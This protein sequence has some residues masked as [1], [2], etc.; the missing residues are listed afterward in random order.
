M[1]LSV[2]FVHVISSFVMF[3][4]WSVEVLTVIRDGSL[5]HEAR[6]GRVLKILSMLLVLATGSY[7]MQRS[8]GPQPWLVVSVLMLLSTIPLSI[9]LSICPKRSVSSENR[10]MLFFVNGMYKLATALGIVSLMVFKDQS[11]MSI[12]IKVLVIYGIILVPSISFYKK[13]LR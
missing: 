4:M 2:L 5:E 12:L 3:S 11:Y 7:L 8:W 10:T 1:Y 9:V 13:T 6:Y